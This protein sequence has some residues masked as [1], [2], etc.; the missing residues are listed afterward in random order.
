MIEYILCYS[1]AFLLGTGAGL[2]IAW[3]GR[4]LIED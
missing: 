1:T 3:V 2:T 4:V